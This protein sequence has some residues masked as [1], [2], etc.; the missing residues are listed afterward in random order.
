MRRRL[1][2]YFL[3]QKS[4]LKMCCTNCQALGEK[5]GFGALWYGCT[6]CTD[7]Q[8]RKITFGAKSCWCIKRGCAGR[9]NR[10]WAPLPSRPRN[11]PVSPPAPA[12]APAPIPP[13]QPMSKIIT[14]KCILM[15]FDLLPQIRMAEHDVFS[16]YSTFVPLLTCLTWD[17]RFCSDSCNLPPCCSNPQPANVTCFCFSQLKHWNLCKPHAPA[18]FPGSIGP[19]T[20]WKHFD[21][22]IRKKFNPVTKLG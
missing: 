14:T 9:T 11:I 22:V 6:A 4:S 8:G 13:L 16:S 20:F 7:R 21:T 2:K 10:Q 1:Q 3:V 15:L 17:R 19:M 18:F 5:L 12:T